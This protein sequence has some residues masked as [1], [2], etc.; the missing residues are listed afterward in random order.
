MKIA[1]RLLLMLTL[2]VST[3]IRTVRS[4]SDL[5][6]YVVAPS[7]NVLLT[8][9]SQPNSP[10]L[11]EQPV[12]LI[13]AKPGLQPIFRYRLRNVS[14]KTVVRYSLAY[15]TSNGTGG[16]LGTSG[17]AFPEKIMPGD[18]WQT[19]RDSIDVLSLTD[20]LRTRLKLT[21][22]MRSVTVLMV[23]RVVFEDGSSYNADSTS[24][25]LAQFFEKN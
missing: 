10:L 5:P 17:S 22:E 12:L 24:D 23:R 16:S 8:V 9:A 20:Q 13:G 6:A 7:E 18:V 21:G 11:I 1:V 3:F 14:E 4:Q 2:T 25:A 19:P 15:W